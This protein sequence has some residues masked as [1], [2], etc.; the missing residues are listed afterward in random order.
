[1]SYYYI[2]CKYTSTRDPNT[3]LLFIL[4]YTLDLVLGQPSPNV[5]CTVYIYR[6]QRRLL[7]LLCCFHRLHARVVVVGQP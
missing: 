2:I 1:M 5:P 3:P 6:P 7:L 4:F